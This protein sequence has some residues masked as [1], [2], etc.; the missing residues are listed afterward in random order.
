VQA[1][2][3]AGPVALSAPLTGLSAL[4]TVHYR[5]VATSAD[6]TTASP[7]ATFTT[8]SPPPVII[9][10]PGVTLPIVVPP[11]PTPKPRLTKLKIAPTAFFAAPAT[12]KRKT[13]ATISYTDSAAARATFVVLR[14]TPGVRHG[15]NCV[16]KPK[17]GHGTACTL[18][19][20]VGSLTHADKAGAN[21]L[22]F[23]GR[24]G[25]HT[26]V[27]GRYRLQATP[28]LGTTAG[29]TVTVSFQIK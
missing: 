7:D 27:L 6:G 22:R 28:K 20:K 26:L 14:S 18:F 4:T 5:L 10:P 17:H 29:T 8:P 25:G 23:T 15:Q 2:G 19:V 9:T 21:T 1:I 12:H 24:V 11:P 16:K 13:G 3:G